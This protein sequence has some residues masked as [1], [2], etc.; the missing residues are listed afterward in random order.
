MHPPVCTSRP[1]KKAPSAA[2]L[3]AA[4][5]SVY[6]VWGSSFLAIRYAVETIPPFF[7][8]ALRSITAGALLYAWARARGAAPPG[9]RHWHPAVVSG[10]LLFL[11]GHG[12]LAWAE[13]SVSSGCAALLIAT[14]PLWAVLLEWASPGGERPRPPV[15]A[16]VL[17]GVMGV[18]IL[19]GPGHP[20]DPTGAS[21]LLLA[22]LSWAAGS[23][24]SRHAGLPE[25]PVLTASLQLIAGGVLLGFAGLA[26]GERRALAMEPVS[27]RSLAALAYLVLFASVLTFTAYT[28]L[29]RVSTPARA[30]SYAFVNPPVALLLG[31]AA[32]DEAPSLRTGLAALA[33]VAAVAL[34]FAARRSGLQEPIGAPARNARFAMAPR[35]DMQGGGAR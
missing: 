21:L 1:Q 29:L 35:I 22:A 25:S 34:V 7:M 26:S 19:T 17:A 18:A 9:P 8:M 13:Q 4:F 15:V 16:G 2:L 31:W 23:V 33:V 20:L 5:A 32:G 12:A 6:L 24:Y 10:G 11:G 30:T 27:L 3:L 28:W 14:I